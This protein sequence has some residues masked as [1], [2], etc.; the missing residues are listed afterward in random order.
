M[1]YLTDNYLT[2]SV[3][4]THQ[5]NYD[6]C[7]LCLLVMK[8]YSFQKQQTYFVRSMCSLVCKFNYM[9]HG[10]QIL[11]GKWHFCHSEI[12]FQSLNWKFKLMKRI[13]PL[14]LDSQPQRKMEWPSTFW[15]NVSIQATVHLPSLKPKFI[16][17]CYQ[18]N[19]GLGGVGVQMLRYWLMT[20]WLTH[21]VNSFNNI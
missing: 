6:D 11:E 20:D 15:I 12:L 7:V 5:S 4:A 9:G 21:G 13:D 18:L 2:V 17:T 16:L 19:V 14:R 1:D 3:W 8:N 10:S